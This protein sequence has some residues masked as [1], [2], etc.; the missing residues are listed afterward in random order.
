MSSLRTRWFLAA[1]WLGGMVAVGLIG[2]PTA[3]A[4]VPE[5]M[6]AAAVASRMFYLMALAAIVFGVLIVALERFADKRAM[7]ADLLLPLGGVFFAVLGEFGVVPRL[8]QAAYSHSPQAGMW[9]GIAS[10]V[11]A[12]QALCV[13][14]YVWRLPTRRKT[15]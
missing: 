13:A 8:L 1:L 12:L 5:K 11:F 7:S 14:A 2:A 3:F 10:L 6:I 9:H 15:A 4:T